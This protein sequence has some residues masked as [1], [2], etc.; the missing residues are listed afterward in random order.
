QA[1]SDSTNA[2]APVPLVVD[3]P[4]TNAS[5]TTA[6]QDGATNSA[7]ITNQQTT[8][9]QQ[10]APTL[11]EGIDFS[12]GVEEIVKLAHAGVSETGILLY[13]E[14]AEHPF[15]LDAAEIVY[16]NDIGV[17]ATVIAAMLNHDG[18]SPEL[19]NVLA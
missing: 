11:P 6:I 9:V 1:G 13:I 14:K 15:D 3:A 2:E 16:L 12:E 8:I 17:S 7:G 5:N 19:H 18:A 4:V 10:I